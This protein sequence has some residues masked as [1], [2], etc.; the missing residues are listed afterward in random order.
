MKINKL[1]FKILF[2]YFFI[3]LML[4]LAFYLMVPFNIDKYICTILTN[5]FINAFII[6]LS[7][8]LIYKNI[9]Y[10]KKQHLPLHC[11]IVLGNNKKRNSINY[12]TKI[13]HCSNSI[14]W[15]CKNVP[16][17]LFVCGLIIPVLIAII[18]KEKYI[19]MLCL[20]SAFASDIF[21][22]FSRNIF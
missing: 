5:I 19:S 22:I 20:L 7:I 4:F 17:L 6:C 1:I 18:F 13:I 12:T 2:L 10:A 21:Y 8:F 15:I 14:Y 16:F 11:N 3:F 9:K